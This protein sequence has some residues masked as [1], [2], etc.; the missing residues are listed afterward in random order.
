MKI[1]EDRI[2]KDG[3]IFEDNVLKV[4]GF[5]NHQID[6]VLMR[7]M[8][9]EW[10]ELY[11][12]EK[13]DKILTIEASGI[14]MATMTAY[15]FGVPLLFAKKT[16]TTNISDNVYSTLIKSYTHQIVYNVQVEKRFLEKGENIL[17][18]DD[19]LA[20]GEALRGLINLCDQAE[21]H[22][23][24]CGIAVEKAFQPGGQELRQK[25]YRIESLARIKSM[26]GQNNIEF[27]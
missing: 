12:G 22:V 14:S 21:A 3:D 26:N 23:V 11:K 19:F 6:P 18:I 10:K 24:G 27:C 4:S 13:V 15:E 25:G 7:D 2:R 20:R 17:I 5:L 8:A 16:K 9:L 1:L